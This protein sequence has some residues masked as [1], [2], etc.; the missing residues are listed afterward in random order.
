MGIIL[1]VIPL[2]LFLDLVSSLPAKNVT[3]R[4][5]WMFSYSMKCVLKS[6][7]GCPGE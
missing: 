5:A 4:V 2:K 6:R 3:T 1:K 7:L